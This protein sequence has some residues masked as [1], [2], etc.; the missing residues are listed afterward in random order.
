MS[1]LLLTWLSLPPWDIIRT[2]TEL[3]LTYCNYQPLPLFAPEHL[4][5][6]LTT[7]D[8][9]LLLAILG[10]AMRFSV[11][12]TA[13]L[14]QNRTSMA[15]LYASSSR[16]LTLNRVS[17]GPVELSTIQTLC[18][19]SLL[20]FNGRPLVI[21]TGL[22]NAKALDGNAHHASIYSSLALDLALSAG[23]SSE[24]PGTQQIEIH[25]ERRRCYWSVVLLKNLYGFPSG[26]LSFLQDDKT[27]KPFLS[28]M[29]P[30]GTSSAMRDASLE[31]PEGTTNPDETKDLGIFMYAI[32]LSEIW[33]KAA[34]CAHRR[35]K[36]GGM[37]PSW[38]AQSEYGQTVALLM[39]F[40]SKFPW[41]YRFRPGRFA[42]Q[43]PLQL[44][45]DREFWAVWFFVQMIYHSILCLLNHPL[46]MSLALRNFKMTQ[47]PEVFL[48]HTAYLTTTHT[49]WI[50]HLLDLANQK[51]LKL[52]DPFLAHLVAITAT[53]YL[54]QSY[55]ED[56]TVRTRKKDCFR[57]C[58]SFVRELGSY[59]PY[60]D[61]LVSV[62]V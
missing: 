26:S 11:E 47:V 59:W 21:P 16:T 42:D 40:E 7:R 35:G 33:Q 61:Q 57:K 15:S 19:L 31:Q 60:I 50:I 8:P 49:N 55:S 22:T 52:C 45:E 37:W 36:P 2:F 3:Y 28:P 24:Y 39:E 6:T 51:G 27:P 43:D 30:L 20:E 56:P 34:R 58:V 32:Q 1:Y 48:Q 9:E 41:K 62:N 54:Q 18:I 46:I 44:R 25:Q 29:P 4:L 5:G 17:H 53:I 14:A 38:S 12:S 13:A 10:L 23:L